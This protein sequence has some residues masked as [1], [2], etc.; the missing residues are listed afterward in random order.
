M[1]LNGFNYKKDGQY[2]ITIVSK[3]RHPFFGEIQ[4]GSMLLN[5]FGQIVLQSWEWLENHFEY[6]ELHE[7]VIM[8]DHLHGIIE[9]RGDRCVSR[10]TS[11]RPPQKNGNR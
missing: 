7:F 2:F 4:N 6:V 3:K 8:P 1:R 11:T 10:N 9:L 5:E